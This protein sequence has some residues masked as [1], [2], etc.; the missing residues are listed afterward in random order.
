MEF[1]DSH[2]HLNDEKFDEDRALIIRKIKDEE[3]TGLIC[4]GYNLE[5][6]K[7][8]CKLACQYDFINATV[9]NFPK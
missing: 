9:R 8:A 7:K 1:F 5:S 2:A 3:I 4:A 6:S